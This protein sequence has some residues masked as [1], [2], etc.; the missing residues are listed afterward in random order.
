MSMDQIALA[1]ECVTLARLQFFEA[2]VLEP[3]M[4]VLGGEMKTPPGMKEA[5]RQKRRRSRM[6]ERTPEQRDAHILRAAAVGGFPIVEAGP[7][8]R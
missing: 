7:D 6:P 5:H 2:V 8:Y 4:T 1:S 3:L